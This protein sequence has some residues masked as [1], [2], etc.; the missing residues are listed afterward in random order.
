MSMKW[1]SFLLMVSWIYYFSSG[2]CGK[3]LVTPMEYSHW[4]NVKI[5]LHELVQ[6]GHEVTVLLPSASIFVDPNQSPTI[7]FE[8]YTT[9]LTDTMEQL[10]LNKELITKLQKSEF[11][12]IL[13]DAFAC[14][15]EL[16]GELLRLLFVYT[17]PFFPGYTYERS[18]GGLPVPP[19]YV[20]LVMSEVTDQMTFIE[21]VKNMVSPLFSDFCFQVFTVERWDQFYSEVLGKLYLFTA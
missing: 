11:D 17:L 5:I 15:G 2:H 14:C 9:S 21:R 18:S 16:L 10:V 13:A 12:I 19:S 8:I 3:V 1:L 4:I 7:K 20:P 6:R